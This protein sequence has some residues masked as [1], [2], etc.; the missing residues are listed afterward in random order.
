MNCVGLEDIISFEQHTRL[1]DNK[2]KIKNISNLKPSSFG[3]Y[4]LTNDYYFSFQ[5]KKYVTYEKS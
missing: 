3:F 2:S 4:S 1:T 5:A